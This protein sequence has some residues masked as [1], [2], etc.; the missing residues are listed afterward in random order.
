MRAWT[1]AAALVL[2]LALSSAPAAAQETDTERAAER[3]VEV[4]LTPKTVDG[5]IERMVG[6]LVE[7]QPGLRPYRDVLR[8]FYE[9]HLG[10]EP[11]S[12]F[13]VGVYADN[14]TAGEMDEIRAFYETPTGRKAMRMMPRLF[15][16]GARWGREQVMEHREE[17]I[18]ELEA[19]AERR[20]G[21]A[22]EE[23]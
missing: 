6:M 16:I 3:L 5:M 9:R 8:A 2:A 13:M 22:T 17:L 7:N 1:A 4:V 20:Q 23:R 14:F 19:A 11:M 10:H 18:D 12:R 15:R 21:S